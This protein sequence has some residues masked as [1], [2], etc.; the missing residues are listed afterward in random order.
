MSQQPVGDLI[1][2]LQNSSDMGNVTLAYTQEKLINQLK[3]TEYQVV[4]DLVGT[5]PKQGLQEEKAQ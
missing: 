2:R 1:L 5:A 3:T 4:A